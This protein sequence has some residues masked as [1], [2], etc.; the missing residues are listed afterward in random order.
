MQARSLIHERN[1]ACSRRF[2]LFHR[3]IAQDVIFVL[4]DLLVRRGKTFERFA[5]EQAFAA[6]AFGG[7]ELV[8]LAGKVGRIDA[9][10]HGPVAF[11]KAPAAVV[12]EA[13]MAGHAHQ[14]ANRGRRA[15]DI[16]H[17]IQ[18]SR[19]RSRGAGTHRYQ[20]RMAAV[21]EPLAGG[22]LKKLDPFAAVRRPDFAMALGFA[23]QR[24]RHKG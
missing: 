15:A 19:H 7:D 9:K 10:H 6:N 12:G 8:A 22:R 17:R 21:A 5:I 1:T 16:E 2:Q 11:E 4:D 3:I 18:H 13:R 24:S 23:V 20:K 14:A